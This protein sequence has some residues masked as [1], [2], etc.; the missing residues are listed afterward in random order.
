MEN[1]K[2]SFYLGLWQ[3]PLL[4]RDLN[5][6]SLSAL[7]ISYNLSMFSLEVFPMRWRYSSSN[8]V[9]LPFLFLVQIITLV[10]SY[11]SSTF[12][13]FLP[14]CYFLATCTF[15]PAVCTYISIFKVLLA[16]YLV[17]YPYRSRIKIRRSEKMR[18]FLILVY[19]TLPPN[20]PCLIWGIF[21]YYS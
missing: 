16:K 7:L 20:W 3:N 4:L 5:Y 12:Q 19:C 6:V 18:S 21:D 17:D 11:F 10:Y 13:T 14:H 2:S 8:L 9:F 1:L 15:S